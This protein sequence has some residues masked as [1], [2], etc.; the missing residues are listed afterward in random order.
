MGAEG[1]ETVDGAGDAV[2]GDAFEADFADEFGGL[3]EGV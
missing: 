2:E 3:E 1:V